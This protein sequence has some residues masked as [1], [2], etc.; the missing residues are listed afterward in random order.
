VEASIPGIPGTL[1]EAYKVI[2]LP[3]YTS[4]DAVKNAYRRKLKLV[5]PDRFHERAA[6]LQEIAARLTLALN[7]AFEMIEASSLASMA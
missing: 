3:I 7:L 5:H 2:G 6:H 1:A 4:I